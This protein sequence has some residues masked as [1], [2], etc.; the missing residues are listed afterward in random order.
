MA[1]KS[2]IEAGKGHVS[3]ATVDTAFKQGLENAK[4]D[5]QKWGTAIAGIGASIAAGGAAFQAPF[6]YALSVLSQDGGELS[7]VSRQT[8]IDV[9]TLGPLLYAVGGDADALG[10]SMR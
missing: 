3:L 1:S 6:H 5:F 7:R 2:S 8:G 10:G 9:A 4:K